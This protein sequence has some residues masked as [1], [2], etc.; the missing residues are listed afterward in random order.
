MVIREPF[1]RSQFASVL[2]PSCHV[3]LT[4]VRFRSIL[5][6]SGMILVGF[7]LVQSISMITPLESKPT[8]S[9]AAFFS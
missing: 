4:L 7:L 9:T 5:S 3:L 8:I 2:L 6:S 1:E